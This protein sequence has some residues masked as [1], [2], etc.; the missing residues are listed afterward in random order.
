MLLKVLGRF[1][2]KTKAQNEIKLHIQLYLDIKWCRLS[3]VVKH[4]SGDAALFVIFTVYT[5]AIA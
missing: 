3:L 2:S 5:I 1:I 4:L